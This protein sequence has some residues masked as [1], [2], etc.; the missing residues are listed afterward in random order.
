MLSK[1]WEWYFYCFFKVKEVELMLRIIFLV[2]IL[3]PFSVQAL[4]LDWSGSYQLEFNTLQKGDFE[5]WGHSELFHNLHLKPDIKA[6]DG[7]RVRSWFQFVSQRAGSSVDKFSSQE[8]I[9]FGLYN[10]DDVSLPF[11]SVR[12]LYLEVTHD[13]GLLQIG[14][15]PHHFGLGMFYNDS[16]E[17]FSPVYNLEGSKGFISWRGFIGSSYYIQPMVHYLDNTLFNLFIQAGFT[18]D[19]Y[20]LEFMYKARSQGL[21]REG[22]EHSPSY[23]GAYAYYKKDGLAV[24][25]EGGMSGDEEDVYGGVVDV[26][27]QTPVSW[28]NVGLDLGIATTGDTESFSFDPS[29]SS[30]LSFLIEEYKKPKSK[31][32]SEAESFEILDSPVPSVVDSAGKQNLNYYAFNSAFYIA[33]S[34]RFSL[35]DSLSLQPVFSTHFSYSSFNILLHHAELN[36]EYQLVEGLVWNTGVGV[37]FPTDDDDWHFG[38]ISQAAI[39]F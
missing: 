20:G 3:L 23:I 9:G 18:R 39:T 29:Y 35:S 31:A 28:L 37:L 27:W 15:K 36:L 38:V 16:S 24:S 1:G 22:L 25:I 26:D 4:V 13:F 32:S 8:G 6:F 10:Q 21:K 7:V 17:L 11:L 34:V 14:W 2:F 19:N 33:P 30:K 5:E 12:D